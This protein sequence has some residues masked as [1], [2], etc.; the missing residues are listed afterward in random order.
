MIERQGRRLRK[1]KTDEGVWWTE[2][3][4]KSRKAVEREGLTREFGGQRLTDRQVKE[5]G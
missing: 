3:D 4:R 5:G 1:R 2:I